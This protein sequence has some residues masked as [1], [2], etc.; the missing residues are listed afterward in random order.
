MGPELILLVDH[1]ADSPTTVNDIHSW[2]RHDP[3]LAQVLQF[4]EHGWPH[5]TDNS[6]S[7]YSSHKTE[8]SVHDGCILWA[9]RV[10]VPARSQ[11]A[12]LQE[13]HSAPSGMTKMKSLAR[14]YVW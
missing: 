7:P 5:N 12:V 8:L 13:L 1:L 3:V 6:F 9:S 4:I 14:M 10:V 2:T 11:K